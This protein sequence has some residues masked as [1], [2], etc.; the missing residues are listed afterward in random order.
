MTP[1]VPRATYRVQFH[2]G[3]TFRDAAGLSGYL[4]AL[5]ISHVYASS[6]LTAVPG[7]THGYDVADPTTLNPE[8]GT[9]DDYLGWVETL[10]ARGMGH[11]LDL[12]PN[13]MGIARGANPWWQDVLEN[14]PASR[15]AAVFDIDWHPLQP[16]LT[17]RVL[18]PILGDRYG[19]VL[20]RQEIRLE[21][22]AGA[23]RLRYFDTVLPVAPDTYDRVL[24]ADQEALLDTLGR[25]SAAATEF[26]SI[27][28]AARRLPP[29]DTPDPAL[30]DERQRE[31]EVVKRRL[32][33]L[34]ADTPPVA[35][36]LARMV[37]RFNGTPGDP[38]SFDPL[39]R[40]LGDQPYRL[41]YWRVA[42]EEINY[43]RFFDINELAATR[44]EDPAVFEL[45][46][47]FVFDLVR[48]GAIDGLRIDHVDGLFDPA[49]YLERVQARAREIRDDGAG[50]LFV[51]VEKILGG[52]EDLR[53][54]PVQG[55][56][57]YDFLTRLNGLFVDPAQQAALT[58][59][60]RQFTRSR[61]PF[62]EVAYRSKQLVL[63][64]SMIS[65]LHALGNQ[66]NR[67]SERNRHYRDFTLTSLIHVLGEVIACFPVYRTYVGDG[68]VDGQDAA[69]IERA[70]DDARRRNPGDPGIIFDFVRDLLLT[71][72]DYI[73]TREHEAHL[74][75]VGKFQQV[76]SPVIAKGV[77]D[78][79]FYRY[80]RLASLNEVG[81]EPDRFGT[82]PAAL[83]AWLGARRDRWPQALSTTST[84]D[85]KRSEDVRA[86]LDVLSEAPGAWKAALARWT[87]ANRRAR[88]RVDGQPYPGRDEEY[89][90]YQTLI[91][92][93][94]LAPMNAEAA[95]IYRERIEAYMEKALREAKVASTWLNPSVP[96]ETA[97]RGFIGAVLGDTHQ[98]FRDDLGAFVESI[99]G[100][101]LVNA[102]AQL[103]TKVC[104]P[105][106]P[107]FYQGAELWDLSL[108][109][110]DNR[111]PVDYARRAA[112]LAE[113]DAAVAA[114]GR[115]AVCARLAADLRDDRA[116]LYA[117]ATLLRHRAE[118]EALFAHGSYEAL[119]VS[120]AAAPHAF[121]FARGHDTGRTLVVVPRLLLT[122]ETATGASGPAAWGDTWI[123]AT[124]WARYRH[125]LSDRELL[126][127]G[128]D[129]Q[130]G[131][132]VADV[133]A[134]FPV[135]VL[136]EIPPV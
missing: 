15:Y 112:L 54:W 2:A 25:D 132:R 133:L 124:P 64:T 134:D 56:T 63:R 130:T 47:G 1:A 108:V 135:A 46:H 33:A 98:G 136:E 120:G 8:V 80:T 34:A 93:W 103:V 61:L 122:L 77:E 44:M 101:G 13:H 89:L 29:R 92:S 40:L 7:S 3:F 66:L 65:E 62:A 43:R 12:V 115:A 110:P 119:A 68:P 50:P 39:D 100:Y 131:L 82:P 41:A 5:G 106:V 91:G 14:G 20:E 111:R 78:T 32:D 21:Y 58:R 86:R 27:V 23:F 31:K 24:C 53:D 84:H 88:T 113:L 99:V 79:A 57:G 107:D 109:D 6:Y 118:R 102:L 30:R 4:D 75:F 69:H 42:A 70:V 90:L 51:V 26:L 9:E 128:I 35:A 16:E 105:G 11:I 67:F 28:T 94:P 49:A 38:E 126:P 121:A 104:A 96:H 87:R 123:T 45:V 71:R 95:E 97:M 129:G 59:V 83:H 85:T 114:E 74:Q 17:N 127:L 37:D 19:V 81:G 60:Y 18:L 10:R 48:R 52:D 72:A 76:T 73:P 116:K 36:Y 55:T 125:V 22:E 117:T